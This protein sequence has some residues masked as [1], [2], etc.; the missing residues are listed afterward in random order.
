MKMSPKP[1]SRKQSLT[2]VA[3]DYKIRLSNSYFNENVSSDEI[4]RYSKTNCSRCDDVLEW[5]KCNP[6]EFQQL[7]KLASVLLSV[8][9]SEAM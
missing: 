6:K 1:K 7:P 5:W 8:P 4:D 2:I 3:I 9:A